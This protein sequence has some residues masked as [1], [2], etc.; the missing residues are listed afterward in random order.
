[1]KKLLLSSVLLS[2][3]SAGAWGQVN[4]TTF[5]SGSAINTAVGQNNVIGIAYAGNEGNARNSVESSN[6][7]VT[8]LYDTFLRLTTAALGEV[9]AFSSLISV[10]ICL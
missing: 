5:V 9:K 7:R 8:P 3:A 2:L 10:G 1:M 6:S 4:F